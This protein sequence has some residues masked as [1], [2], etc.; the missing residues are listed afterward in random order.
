M[1]PSMKPI[2]PVRTMASVSMP[3]S[4]DPGDV[5]EGVAVEAFHHQ[6]PLGDQGG[7]GAGMT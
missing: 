7:V 4:L 5:V 1:H 6:D 2:M 3:A